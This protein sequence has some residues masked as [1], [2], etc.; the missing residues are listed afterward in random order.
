MSFL[1]F[2]IFFFKSQLSLLDLSKM[3]TDEVFSLALSGNSILQTRGDWGSVR[4]YEMA[5]AR[6]CLGI[7]WGTLL[8]YL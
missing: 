5:I 3:C 8:T 6:S 7:H 1:K 4:Q 2:A